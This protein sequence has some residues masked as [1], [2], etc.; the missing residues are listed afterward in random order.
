MPII[1]KYLS[2]ILRFYS[3]EHLPIYVNVKKQE[4]EMKAEFILEENSVTLLFKK[5][6]GKEPMTEKEVALFLKTCQKQIIEKW[7]KVFIYHQK[8]EFEEIKT[9]IKKNKT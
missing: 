3:N 6:K 4:R 8:V 1:F 7:N 5:V 2:F 9:R